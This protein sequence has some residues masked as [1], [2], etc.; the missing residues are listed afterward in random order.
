MASRA[1]RSRPT[2]SRRRP[3][4]AGDTR[5]SGTVGPSDSWPSPRPQGVFGSLSRSGQVSRVAHLTV[6]SHAA[7]HYPGGPPGDAEVDLLAGRLAFPVC[8]SGRLPRLPFR[9]LLGLHSRCGLLPPRAGLPPAGQVHLHGARTLGAH[10]MPFAPQRL[11][12]Q[13]LRGP[14]RRASVQA[15]LRPCGALARWAGGAGPCGAPARRILA[16]GPVSSSTL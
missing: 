4:A 3:V 1:S 7:P 15:H 14:W 12:V 11:R 13:G 16:A 10:A 6:C 9:G 5:F 8:A 2:R